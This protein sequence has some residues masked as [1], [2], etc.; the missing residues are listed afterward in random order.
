MSIEIGQVAPDFSLVDSEG[1]EVRLSQFRGNQ[2]V[3]L[4]FFPAAF[5]GV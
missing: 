4:F 2:N 1:N 3:A 5:T